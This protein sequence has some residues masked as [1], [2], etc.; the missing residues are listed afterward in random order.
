MRFFCFRA[1][2]KSAKE[3][4]P[5]FIQWYWMPRRC[6]KSPAASGR[7]AHSS[8]VLKVTCRLEACISSATVTSARPSVAFTARARSA[9]AGRA[10]SRGPV[11]GENGTQLCSLG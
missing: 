3:E 8:S 1:I 11:T 7:S 10:S 4:K 6:K 2:S 5:R 9:S